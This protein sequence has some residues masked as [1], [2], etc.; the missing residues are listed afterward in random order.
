M[1]RIV[2]GTPRSARMSVSSSSSQSIGLPANC[3]ASDSRNFMFVVSC[4]RSRGIS[5]F[6]FQRL[7][8][9]DQ[10]FID[11]ARNDNLVE[12]LTLQPCNESR[13]LLH[14]LTSGAIQIFSDTVENTVHKS[15]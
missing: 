5:G 6:D 7:K 1:M 13:F 9:T 8:K 10:K 15:A 12:T 2:I 11:V 4:R 14:R 3:F